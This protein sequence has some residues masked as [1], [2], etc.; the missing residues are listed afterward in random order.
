MNK[1]F[2]AVAVLH[3]VEA[4]KL[5]L[6]DPILKFLPDYPNKDLASKVTV[7]NLLTHTGGTRDI[8]GQAFA[9]NRMNLKEHRDYLKLY[10]ARHQVPGGSFSYSNSRLVLLGA[11]I[12]QASGISY[13]A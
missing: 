1:M 7:R 3:L 8:F 2:T 9:E 12:A 5:A 11:L 6:S 4:G 13:H 10:G